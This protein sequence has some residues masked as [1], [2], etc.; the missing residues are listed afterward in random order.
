MMTK[1]SEIH[2]QT[3]FASISFGYSMREAF[4]KQLLNLFWFTLH[5]CNGKVVAGDLFRDNKILNLFPLNVLNN[6]ILNITK[7]ILKTSSVN[8]PKSILWIIYIQQ[9]YTTIFVKLV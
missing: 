6:Q 5:I 7:I 8:L 1:K 2:G 9:Q 3:S 4:L